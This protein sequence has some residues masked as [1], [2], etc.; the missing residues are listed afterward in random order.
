MSPGV[1]SSAVDAGTAFDEEQYARIYPPGI[2]RHYWTRARNLIVEREIRRLGLASPPILEVGCGQGDLTAVLAHAC[3]PEGH[4]DAFDPA[5][6]GYGAPV[7]I[8][9]SADC[10]LRSPLGDERLRTGVLVPVSRISM[11]NALGHHLVAPRGTL[12]PAVE[13][14]LDSLLSA[15]AVLRA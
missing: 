7:T 3:G 2:E 8:G 13:A 14:V 12:R 9:D 15:T 1:E 10:L 4:I 11:P 5:P 6:P